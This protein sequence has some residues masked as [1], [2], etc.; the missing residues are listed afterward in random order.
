MEKLM[1]IL[2]VILIAIAKIDFGLIDVSKLKS[3]FVVVEVIEEEKRSSYQLEYGATIADLEK[4]AN[5]ELVDYSLDYK[6]HHQERIDLRKDLPSINDAKEAD[7]LNVPYIDK[8][9]INSI[10]QYREKN[11]RILNFNDLKSIKGMG[12]AKLKIL[13]KYFKL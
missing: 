10:L 3:S 2:V 11:G 7:F 6:L 5:I 4:Q 13:M 8:Q 9:L 12:E 1:F